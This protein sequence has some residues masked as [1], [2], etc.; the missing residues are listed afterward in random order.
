MSTVYHITSVGVVSGMYIYH[1][2][3][4]ITATTT[5]TTTTTID[6]HTIHALLPHLQVSVCRV[7]DYNR[8]VRDI[9]PKGRLHVRKRHR[10]LTA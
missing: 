2:Y 1:A 6:I 5:T 3:T 10:H 9:A 7:T 4:T 8:P